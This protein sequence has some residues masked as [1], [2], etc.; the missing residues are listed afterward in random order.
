MAAVNDACE[1]GPPMRLQF[2]L[3]P[4][5]PDIRAASRSRPSHR[6]AGRYHPPATA[7]TTSLVRSLP[8]VIVAA[9]A[10]NES[11]RR[12]F[13]GHRQRRRHHHPDIGATGRVPT[14]GKMAGPSPG[15]RP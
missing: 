8:S 15:I 5:A 6:A 13:T 1:P 11:G 4:T 3:P 7:T 9:T 12:R 2:P 14:V 10:R